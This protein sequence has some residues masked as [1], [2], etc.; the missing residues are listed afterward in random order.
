MN[1]IQTA[2]ENVK[3]KG[4]RRKEMQQESSWSYTLE[5]PKAIYFAF[6]SRS[7]GTESHLFAY[8]KGPSWKGSV[9]VQASKPVS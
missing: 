9:P 3:F 2:K 1:I 5:L 8:W 7:G 4:K 6:Q